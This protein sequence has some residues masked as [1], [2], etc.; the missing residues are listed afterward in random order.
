[1]LMTAP[2]PMVDVKEEVLVVKE[3]FGSRD[4]LSYAVK[5]AYRVLRWALKSA[6]LLY[7]FLILGGSGDRGS[8]RPGY[9]WRSASSDLKLTV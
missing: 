5:E 2:A 8:V 3:V 7:D 6:G 1:M 4:E 9:I